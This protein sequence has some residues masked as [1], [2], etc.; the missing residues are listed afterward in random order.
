MPFARESVVDP[1]LRELPERPLVV[2]WG[3]AVGSV[4]LALLTNWAIPHGRFPAAFF[5]AAV[6]VSAH[7]GGWGPALFSFVLSGALLDYYFMP[8]VGSLYITREAVPSISQFLVPSGLGCWLVQRRKKA[9]LLLVRKTILANSL[10]SAQAERDKKVQ[11]E[12]ERA[13]EFR[14]L[15]VGLICHDLRSPLSAAGALTQLLLQTRGL[16]ADASRRLQGVADSL[17]RID[18]LIGT[19]LDFTESRFNG[20][21]TIATTPTDLAE[22]CARVASNQTLPV[23]GRHIDV[24]CDGPMV[25]DWDPVRMTQVV[26]NLFTNALEHGGAQPVR[27]RLSEEGDAVI[28]EVTNSDTVI[29]PD[30]M[31]RLFEPFRRSRTKEPGGR[32]GLGLGLYVVRQ[33][34][35]AHGGSVIAESTPQRGTVFTVR[36]PRLARRA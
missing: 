34:V 17:E 14:E 31:G 28:L 20:A 35:L 18:T 15:V 6:M 4:V 29:P 21:L 9:E 8:P 5:T 24:C 25:G 7:V 23:Q 3:V 30:R 27:V 12:L 2:R 10:A 11:R 32:P 16:P 26:S 13:L 36:L 1:T 19:L 33:I 22:V